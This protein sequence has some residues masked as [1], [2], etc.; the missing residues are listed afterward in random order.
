MQDS[1]WVLGVIFCE[2]VTGFHPFFFFDSHQKY[3]K[4]FDEKGSQ[5]TM[6]EQGELFL[7]SHEASYYLLKLP[8]NFTLASLELLRVLLDVEMANRPVTF[9]QILNDK[10]FNHDDPLVSRV[11]FKEEFP[12]LF[13]SL[14]LFAL[15]KAGANKELSSKSEKPL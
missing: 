4:S 7:K 1:L 14:D 5:L 13:N 15:I 10:F 9:I 6:R 3:L 2:M 11:Q 8:E 12:H